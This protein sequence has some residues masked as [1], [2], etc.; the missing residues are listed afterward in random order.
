M[1]SFFKKKPPP[2]PP[3]SPATPIAPST[4]V[5]PPAPPVPGALGSLIGRALV[6][7]ID[8]ALPG[9]VP[10]ERQKWLDKLKSGLGKTASSI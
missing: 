1:F 2:T 7:P 9:A 4:A 10:A 3:A 8:I 5:A 6:T